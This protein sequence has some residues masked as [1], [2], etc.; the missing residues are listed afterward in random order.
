M[1]VA[2]SPALNL[3]VLICH[4]FRL[5]RSPPPVL[6]SPSPS[7]PSPPSN[8]AVSSLV[9]VSLG[10]FLSPVSIIGRL[11]C[12]CLRLGRPRTLFQGFY[13]EFSPGSYLRLSLWRCKDLA[14]RGLPGVSSRPTSPGVALRGTVLCG[15]TTPASS[16]ISFTSAYLKIEILIDIPLR[17][18]QRL[19]PLFILLS[20][21][22]IAISGVSYICASSSL[23]ILF[24]VHP[25]SR[26]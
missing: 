6:H 12:H 11:L 23:H 2:Y 3:T 13:P 1:I 5:Q 24:P 18:I 19:L 8:C 26:G 9:V 22:L 7:P 16:C 21:Y 20:F 14:I 15:S 17:I 10:H 25:L 4:H